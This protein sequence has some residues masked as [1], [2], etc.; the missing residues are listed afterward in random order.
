MK[1]SGVFQGTVTYDELFSKNGPNSPVTKTNE[2]FV[3]TLGKKILGFIEKG[4]FQ[5]IWTKMSIQIAMNI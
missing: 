1:W 3:E 5:T 4:P 2:K